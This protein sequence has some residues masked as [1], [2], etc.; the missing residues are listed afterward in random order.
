[1]R[2]IAKYYPVSALVV[3]AVL[4]LSFFKPPKTAISDISNI[5]KIIH[6]IMYIGLSL[7]VW[8][9][10]LRKHTGKLSLWRGW[11]V[12]SLFPIILGGGIELGQ[13]Y[14]TSNRSGEWLDF[15]ADTAGV[16]VISLIIT[17]TMLCKR[18]YLQPRSK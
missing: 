15:A 18:K 2:H 13:E 4:F 6:A 8:L 14:L 17:I 1:M 10:F 11:L 5:D 12:A 3:L 9:E 16:I 7:I